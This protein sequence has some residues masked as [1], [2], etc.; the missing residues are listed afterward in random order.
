MEQGQEQRRGEG[1][2]KDKDNRD[3]IRKIRITIRKMRIRI[4]RLG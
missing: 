3:K 1:G 2:R 4:S